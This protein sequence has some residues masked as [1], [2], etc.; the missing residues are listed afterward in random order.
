MSSTCEPADTVEYELPRRPGETPADGGQAVAAPQILGCFDLGSLILAAFGSA[1]LALT[2]VCSMG[3]ILHDELTPADWLTGASTAALTA[4]FTLCAGLALA[5]QMRRTH[6]HLIESEE[7]IRRLAHYDAVTGLPNRILLKD[8]IRKELSAAARNR[9]S[10]A[11][12]FLDLDRFKAV[13]DSLG[14]QAGDELLRTVGERLERSLREVDT[15]ARLGGDEFIV[16]LPQTDAAGA[17]EVAEKIRVAIAESYEINGRQIAV[18][19]SIG[20]SLYPDDGMDM[21]SLMRNADTAMYRAKQAGSNTF[22]FFAAARTLNPA[23][24]PVNHARDIRRALRDDEFTIQYQ[25]QVDAQAGTIVAV[26]AQLGWKHPDRGLLTAREFL[27]IAATC[28]LLGTLGEWYLTRA[29]KQL[30]AWHATGLLRTAVVIHL[31]RLQV[32]DPLLVPSIRRALLQTGLEPSHWEIELSESSLG[33]IPAGALA[34][35]LDLRHCGVR[36]ALNEFGTSHA[37]LAQVTKLPVEKLKIDPAFVE[38]LPR[39]Q[40]DALIVASMIDLAH[41]LGKRFVADGVASKAQMS[42]LR[43][44]G[45]DIVQGPLHGTPADAAVFTRALQG[46]TQPGLESVRI[47]A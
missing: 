19:P 47:T 43:A 41:N 27:P 3:V 36:F 11:L 29:G 25:A 9:N 21:D 38:G 45:C 22:R 37:S 10:L 5:R 15:V 44:K 31:S 18:T 13:N 42:Y 33:D 39:N 20:V 8:R 16:V 4:G 17:S 40:F 26:D 24:R 34:R 23:Q 7:R 12:L 14:H 32:C 1:L 30:A 35:L 28:D 46:M 2:S 6:G